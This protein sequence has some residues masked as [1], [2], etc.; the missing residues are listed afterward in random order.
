V[1]KLTLMPVELVI[2]DPNVLATL[3]DP[4]RY[5]LFRLLDEPRSV[6]EL[7]GE[8]DVPANRLYY[9]VRRLAENGLI[10]QVP[11][12]G[13]E[14]LYRARRIRFSGHVA[15]PGGGPLA[16]LMA[17]LSEADFEEDSPGLVSWH[18]P[19]LTPRR[20]AELEWRLQKLIAEFADEE[21]AKGSERYGLLAV[22]ARL[23]R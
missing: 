19:S 20:A 4:L 22:L 12:I 11:A 6:P 13:T 9:H 2:T 21:G 10:E 14:R 16:A 23:R 18:L 3:Y 7:A 1:E 5:R 15:A 17:E 8:V